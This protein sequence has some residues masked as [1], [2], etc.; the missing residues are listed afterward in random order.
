LEGSC[1]E[2]RIAA[3]ECGIGENFRLSY[4]MLSKFSHPTALQILAPSDEA[5]AALQKDLFFSHGCLFFHGAFE[6][7]EKAIDMRA[8][9]AGSSSKGSV[10]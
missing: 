5:R 1:K 4:R 8:V 3:D 9:V 2:V 7:I 10:N 6:A